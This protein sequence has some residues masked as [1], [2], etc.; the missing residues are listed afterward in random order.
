PFHSVLQNLGTTI[1]DTLFS[2]T[3]SRI[4]IV[5][6]YAAARGAQYQLQV[7]LQQPDSNAY[8]FRFMTTGSGKFD[9]WT[10]A[11]FGWSQMV[12]A[13]SVIPTI[14]DFPAMANY[15]FPDN[16]QHIT[17]SWTCSPHVITVANYRNETGYIAYDGSVQQG[18]GIVEGEITASSSQGPTRDDRIKP[19]IAAP[20][21][22]TFSPYPLASLNVMINNPDVIKVAP[23]GMHIRGGGTSASSPHIAGIVALYLKK[24]PQAT[25]SE[26]RNALFTTAV[27]DQ[28]ATD[29]PNTTWGYGKVHAF[30]ALNTSN[31]ENFDLSVQGNDP[32]CA[33]EEITL[34]VP[35]SFEEYEWSTGQTTDQI[36]TDQS[37]TFSLVAYN[38]SHCS[39][40]SDTVSLIMLPTPAAPMITADGYEL[41]SSDAVGYQW[42]FNGIPMDGMDMQM[43][44]A[45]VTG[46][47][48]VEIFNAEGC[49][50]ISDPVFVLVA[51][52]DAISNT[53]AS[54]WPSP[55]RDQ[56]N[57][58]VTD[59]GN[60]TFVILDGRGKVVSRTIG[61]GTRNTSIALDGIS[62]GT[63]F[64]RIEKDNE[65]EIFRFVKL[66]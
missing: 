60:Y 33:G 19:D 51:D 17:D 4:G 26:V 38:A 59:N 52:V 40:R 62:A 31:I 24:C 45:W 10:S 16:Q 32:F 44:E 58:S 34:S 12:N 43:I 7:W 41:T 2:V 6:Y 35:S 25:Y 20:G 1:T 46:D 54:I 61:T 64:L 56:I 21:D 18:A 8:R 48:Q 37:G 28:F 30:A 42:Y 23:G 55:A 47:Y 29:V 15:V 66:P 5:N 63:Y 22:I 13:T 53:S 39:A 27:S 9:V 36:S 11:S 57:V 3:G 14:A 49:S 50:A 65:N